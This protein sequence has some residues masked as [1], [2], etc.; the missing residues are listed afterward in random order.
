MLAFMA[1]AWGTPAT[2]E[3]R[4]R[5]EYGLPHVVA[6]TVVIPMGIRVSLKAKATVEVSCLFNG[7]VWDLLF[8][9][10]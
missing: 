8:S 2:A 3:T 7:A 9:S 5:E 6:V 10:R 1:Q 4:S